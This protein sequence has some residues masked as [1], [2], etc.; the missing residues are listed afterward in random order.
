[1]ASPNIRPPKISPAYSSHRRAMEQV[2]AEAQ[3]IATPA[4]VAVA[5]AADPL[6]H[7][8]NVGV[9]R[10]LKGVALDRAAVLPFVF[11]PFVGRR[12]KRV[13][14]DQPGVGA[15][16]NV[17]AMIAELVIAR[18]QMRKIS[19]RR[20]LHP[21]TLADKNIAAAACPAGE[22]GAN[23]P[24]TA[25]DTS[26]AEHHREVEALRFRFEFADVDLQQPQ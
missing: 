16:L 3:R 12:D 19:R 11:V 4:Q 24:D 8:G 23:A 1:M 10:L 6:E 26:A 9:S 15:G 20:R 22:R 25:T 17:A 18:F 21:V 7:R 13:Q 5:P 2:D 14:R